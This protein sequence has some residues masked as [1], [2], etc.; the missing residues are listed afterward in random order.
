MKT[1]HLKYLLLLLILSVLR[2]TLPAAA[3]DPISLDRRNYIAQ[4]HHLT[5]ALNKRKNHNETS[6]TRIN[7]YC[8]GFSA[9]YGL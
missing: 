4:V 3:Q 5:L 7:K 9:Y 6:K 1:P 8:K 2:D